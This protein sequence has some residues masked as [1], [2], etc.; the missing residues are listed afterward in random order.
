MAQS[1]H[2]H[3]HSHH[4]VQHPPGPG[5]KRHT[6]TKA[7]NIMVIFMGILGVFVAYISAGPEPLWLIAGAVA[8]VAVGY[9]IGRSMD[10]A[11]GRK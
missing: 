7:I 4:H 10:R 3:K 11:A 6:Q 5:V 9:F 8:G 1:R 2:R